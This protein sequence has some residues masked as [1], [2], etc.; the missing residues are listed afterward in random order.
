MSLNHCTNK[1]EE[2]HPKL[3]YADGSIVL[4]VDSTEQS[5]GQDDEKVTT[6][7]STGPFCPSIRAFSRTCSLCLPAM[8]QE[9]YDGIAMVRLHDDKE[10]FTSLLTMLYN[11]SYLS[12][13]DDLLYFSNLFG[14]LKLAMKYDITCIRNEVNVIIRRDWPATLPAYDRRGDAL[15][16][17]SLG[18][19]A[20]DNI[21]LVHAGEMRSQ[22]AHELALMHYELRG[23]CY[24]TLPLESFGVLVAGQAAL[25][26]MI[27]QVRFDDFD[28]CASTITD[29]DNQELA[30]RFINDVLNLN[31][32]VCIL[33]LLRK[34]IDKVQSGDY[35]IFGC[36]LC[37]TCAEE[38]MVQLKVLRQKIFDDIPLMFGD[39][40]Y[41][42]GLFHPHD[43][44]PFFTTDH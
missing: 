5:K 39:K 23:R 33:Y 34:A 26:A 8:R 3:Y 12:N 24:D 6:F 9:Q 30:L 28:G 35:N 38:V 25:H 32:S 40:E 4:A 7:V 1:R 27:A 20:H 44:L 41:I 19:A 42:D 16:E 21:R 43:Q 31:A 17:L 2:R 14:P 11:R 22:L 10:D 15:R 18:F 29:C 37:R 36:E 13:P